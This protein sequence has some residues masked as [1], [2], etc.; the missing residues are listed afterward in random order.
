M[1]KLEEASLFKCKKEISK[2]WQ[3]KQGMQKIKQE[4]Q[5]SKQELSDT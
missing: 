2:M 4:M 1:P 3:S 5:Q